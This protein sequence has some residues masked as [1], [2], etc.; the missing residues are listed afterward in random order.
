MSLKIILVPCFLLT[1]LTT[2]FCQE[3]ILQKRIQLE[4][5]NHTLAQALQLI[6]Q[7]AGIQLSYSSLVVPQPQLR[8]HLST[9]SGSLE[10]LLKNILGEDVQFQVRGNHIIIG[11]GRRKI[12]PEFTVSGYLRDAQNGEALIGATVQIRELP[13]V[14]V[15]SNA[16]GFYSLSLPAGNYRLICSFI[17]YQDLE[18]A[19][20]LYEPQSRDLALQS[21]SEKLAEVIVYSRSPGSPVSPAQT[22]GNQLDLQQLKNMPAVAGEADLFKLAQT[23]PGVKSVDEGSSGLYVRGGNLDQNLI[24]LDEAPVYNPAHF[25]GFFSAF[26]PDAIRH[27]QLYKSNFPIQYGGRLSSVFDLRMKEGNKEKTG[28]QGGIGLLA[29]RLFV[30][31]PIRKRQSSFMLSARRTYPDLI[32][33]FLP[34]DGG[35]KAHFY[36]LNAKINTQ[37]GKKDH[38]Y[39]SSYLGRDVFRYFDQYENTWSNATLSLRW[40][41]LFNDRLFANFSLIGSRYRYYIDNFIQGETTFNWQSGVNNLNAK[42]DF[43]WYPKNGNTWRFG[44]NL[45][46]IAFDPG[47]DT[48]QR[49]AAVPS[50]QGLESAVYIGREWDLGDRLSVRSGLRLNLFQNLGPALEYQFGDNYDLIDSIHHSAGS[51]EGFLGLAPR[52]F[53]RYQLSEKSALTAAYNRTYQY[54]QEL[55]N[56]NSSFSAFYIWLPSGPNLPAQA[57]DQLSSGYFQQLAGGKLSFSLELYYKWLYRQVD[58]ADHAQLL[59][60]PY[61]EGELRLGKGRAYGLEIQ[62]QKNSGRL[63]GWINYTFSRT[64]RSIP[65]INEGREY[66]AYYDLPHAVNL[67]LQYEASRRWRLALNWQYASGKPAILPIGSYRLGE[68]IVPIYGERNSR[69][70]PDFHRLDLSASLRR[71]DKPGVRNQ[72]YWVFSILNV[73]YRKNAL[74]VDLLP[75]RDPFTGN[76]PDPT[77]VRAYKTYV[78]GVLPSVSYNFKF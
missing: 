61:L 28:V 38:L 51:Y 25:L 72:S 33:A 56:S 69:R 40:N 57:A 62:L 13:G 29:S 39:L 44:F 64:F 67:N 31:G 45:L 26:N 30:E 6:E 77:D 4:I 3:S 36:D 70:L 15:A 71:R 47:S 73:Y 34:D 68:T 55:R 46:K 2:S 53:V 65:Q 16:Y 43:S 18:I 11:P 54:I 60:N 78:F 63:T 8:A 7:T 74:G 49:V 21:T 76:V 9:N 10:Q 66:P 41:H 27:A 50:R 17:G 12:K 24:L 5:K 48:Q 37:I 23:M 42:A 59:Q 32:F 1:L 58:F 52:L 14:G 22:G 19:L 75:W 35:N 20:S